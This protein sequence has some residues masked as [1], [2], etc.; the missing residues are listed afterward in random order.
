MTV[1]TLDRTLGKSDARALVTRINEGVTSVWFLVIQAYTGRAWVNLGYDSW[2]ALCEA[3]LRGARLR[4]SREERQ[5]V[6]ERLR[7]VGLST[8]AIGSALGVGDATVRRD[9]TGAPNDAPESASPNTS[10]GEKSPPEPSSPS[11]VANHHTSGVPN[12]TPELE[13]PRATTTGTDGKTYERKPSKAAVEPPKKRRTQQPVL[14]GDALA[15]YDAEN[16]CENFG[17]ALGSLEGL[18]V[19]EHRGR[20]IEAWKTG[21]LGA[22]PH[23]RELHTPAMIR[24]LAFALISYASDL[25]ERS[26][27]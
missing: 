18:M 4:L 10:G 15:K 11:G 12:G 17:S 13:A 25:E 16:V 8:R 7:G 20:V 24:N 26:N 14:E 2:D 23:N 1:A 27:A 3:E 9:L 5:D 19:P 21:S 22:T 6:V